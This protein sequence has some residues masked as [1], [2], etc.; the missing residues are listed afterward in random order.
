MGVLSVVLLLS[1]TPYN[2]I[3][4]FGYSFVHPYGFRNVYMRQGFVDVVLTYFY[5]Y[6]RCHMQCWS[7]PIGSVALEYPSKGYV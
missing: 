4:G 1:P 2:P 3:F 7:N 5:R 6:R